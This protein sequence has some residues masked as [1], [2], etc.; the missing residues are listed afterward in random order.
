MGDPRYAHNSFIVE[1]LRAEHFDR[2]ILSGDF[3]DLWLSGYKRISTDQLFKEVVELS[4]TKE[5]IWVRGNHDW[6][7]DQ[8]K[9]KVELQHIK[10]VSRLYLK[11][12]NKSI[13]IIHGHQVYS[14]KNRS[15]VIK[16]A[17][18]LNRFV[19]KYTGLDVQGILLDKQSNGYLQSKRRELLNKFG[20]QDYIISGHT[21]KIAYCE[22]GKTKLFD[23]GST[24]A[25]QSYIVVE[26]G[27][28]S[29]QI[30]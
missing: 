12:Q 28:I 20:D 25:T 2:L 13:L 8:Y 26:D 9:N 5:V 27:N 14:T 11:E 30:I 3:A 17:A 19:W 22:N 18:K 29:L 7:I 23:V 6:D 15:W 4:R 16:L 21:H 1:M 24:Y 10:I